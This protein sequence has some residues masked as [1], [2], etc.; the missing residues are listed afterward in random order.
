[1]DVFWGAQYRRSAYGGQEQDGIV[2]VILVVVVVLIW[3]KA[4][5]LYHKHAMPL[6]CC[7]LNRCHH[8][9]TCK[10]LIMIAYHCHNSDSVSLQDCLSI[11]ANAFSAP[12]TSILA[13]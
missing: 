11:E 13:R 10:R 7:S 12:V 9:L 4:E 6:P 1:M 8:T 2:V 3:V 5:P